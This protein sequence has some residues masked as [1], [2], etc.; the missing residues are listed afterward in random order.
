MIENQPGRS[1][2]EQPELKAPSLQARA[3]RS[4]A[5]AVGQLAGSN[6]L[7][8]AGN[9]VLTRLLFPE[10]FGVMG[11]V[12]VFIQGTQLLSDLGVGP[13]IIQN[14]RGD[15]PE[16]LN[17]AWTMQ[18][19]RGFAIW[20][21]LLL[22]AW[23]VA[24]IYGSN[25]GGPDSDT[26]WSR[27]LLMLIPAV[28]FTAV[29][30]GFESTAQFTLNRRLA[31]GR[32]A[33]LELGSQLAGIVVM[34]IWATID[35]TVW[36]L[37]GGAIA[38]RVVRTAGSHFLLP[39]HR[40]KL[41]W[42]PACAR[43]IFRFGKWILAT[44]A[45]GF[46]ASQVDRLILPKLIGL[47]M[48]GIYG[49]ALMLAAVPEQIVATLGYKIVFPIISRHTHLE[50]S[51]LRD[52]VLRVRR[53]FLLALAPLIALLACV[54]DCFVRLAWDPR[55]HAA[56]WMFTIL[57]LGVWPR[58]LTNTIGPALLGIGQPRYLAYSGFARLVLLIVSIPVAH[59][60]F[61]VP[62]VVVAIAVG[63]LADYTVEAFGLWRNGLLALWQDLQMT[64]VWLV[65]LALMMLIRVALGQALPFSIME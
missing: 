31:L 28:G 22:I 53:S 19:L 2:P 43:A 26:D 41:H 49:I 25:A 11:L 51:V 1:D 62:G 46:L 17:T 8:L 60:V 16:F 4:S 27:L 10:A 35:P 5:W 33:I 6:A 58:I 38:T 24:M 23:P 21:C 57:A 45:I 52:R 13:S 47:K 42:D 37:A 50:R 44:S 18:I 3:S 40:N 30:S 54:G 64:V 48:F 61:G 63:G 32:I 20:I 9:L 7:R 59:H 12:Q 65:I 36:A 29:I 34:V 15:D 55:Y 14:E 56:G 39:G